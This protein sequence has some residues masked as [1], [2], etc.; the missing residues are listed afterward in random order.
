MAR[1]HYA[2]QKVVDLKSSEKTQA[3]WLLSAA[4]GKLRSEELTLQNLYEER[5][6]WCQRLQEASSTAVPLSEILVMQ[7]YVDHVDTCIM[8][9]LTDIKKAQREVDDRRNFLS[10]KMKD[11]K[12]WQK[13]KERALDRF[14]A[15]VQSKEQNELDELA[16]VRF[17][18]PA[19]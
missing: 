14:R 4:L 15:V 5:A 11:E 18:V 1:F 2:Y 7:Q 8:R 10:D 3:E 16:T 17:I 9:K 6:E 12:V 19:P 13:S